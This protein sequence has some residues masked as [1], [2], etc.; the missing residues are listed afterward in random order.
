MPYELLAP[1]LKRFSFRAFPGNCI[2]RCRYEIRLLVAG[3]EPFGA[4]H[5]DEVT[6][7]ML[8]GRSAADFES[9]CF[10]R[11]LPTRIDQDS[12]KLAGILLPWVSR[13]PY[14][15]FDWTTTRHLGVLPALS[16][17][18]PPLESDFFGS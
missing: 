12:G 14:P 8:P 16:L 10:L 5:S 1:F 11:D 17:R 13:K 3:I 9:G 7:T 18:P 4:H 15:V 2:A 6:Q